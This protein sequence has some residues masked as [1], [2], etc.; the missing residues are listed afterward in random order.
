MEEM[1]LQNMQELNELRTQM[2]Q[3]RE[4]LDQQ[5]IV[6]DRV[7]RSSMKRRLSWIKRYIWLEIALVPV[8]LIFFAFLHHALGMSW[9]LY[10]L[11]AVM[12]VV[13]VTVDYR[14]NHI[15]DSQLMAGNLTDTARQ[16]Q[17]MKR[18]RAWAFAIEL[19]PLM[20]WLLGL[21]YEFYRVAQ[22]QSGWLQAFA[23]GAIFGTV[24]GCVIGLVVAVVIFVKM[25]RTNDDIIAQI[26]E[27]S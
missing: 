1:N 9:W 16:L 26:D 27:I 17:R 25:Q 22:T 5:R 8:L 20:L 7:L 19:V 4:T 23:Q 24:I 10:G 13:D 2:S 18:L 21:L 15:D 3:L 6:N 11:L 14:V 12:L